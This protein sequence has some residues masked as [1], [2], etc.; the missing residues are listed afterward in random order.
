[1]LPCCWQLASRSS[2]QILEGVDGE[3]LVGQIWQKELTRVRWNARIKKVTHA[4]DSAG[5]GPRKGKIYIAR[6]G[7]A[8]QPSICSSTTERGPSRLP[9]SGRFA[10]ETS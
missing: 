3:M 2:D 10:R 1:V 6:A 8:I 9:C 4:G 5:K 7:S